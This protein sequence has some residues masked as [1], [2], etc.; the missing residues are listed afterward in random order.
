M[1]PLLLYAYR[2]RPWR[3]CLY[4]N[5]LSYPNFLNLFI[6]RLQFLF[7]MAWHCKP[8]IFDHFSQ[9]QIQNDQWWL[10]CQV[11]SSGKV[12]VEMGLRNV[13]LNW[14]L[15]YETCKIYWNLKLFTQILN[16]NL[17]KIQRITDIPT[18]PF[19]PSHNCPS[20][21]ESLFMRRGVN[22]F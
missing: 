20:D 16:K 18:F 4:T 7:L 8:A 21:S 5:H 17:S 19:K 12:L 3:G 15:K 22:Y 6:E 14:Y 1:L 9:K 10:R 13:V 2:S 11:P